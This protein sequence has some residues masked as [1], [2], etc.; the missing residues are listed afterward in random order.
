MVGSYGKAPFGLYQLIERTLTTFMLWSLQGQHIP[1]S[2]F[3]TQCDMMDVRLFM[4]NY[5][6]VF[7]RLVKPQQC[8]KGLMSR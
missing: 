4:R 5:S 2:I 6:R 1:K 7:R 3:V 8:K